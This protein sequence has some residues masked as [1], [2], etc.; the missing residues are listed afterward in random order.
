MIQS[1]YLFLNEGQAL[2]K[3]IIDRY[4]DVCCTTSKNIY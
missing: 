1:L 4:T 2:L 3:I